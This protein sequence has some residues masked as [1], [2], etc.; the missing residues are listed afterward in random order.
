MPLPPVTQL[1]ISSRTLR[2]I[3]H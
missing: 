1:R 2:S 3:W